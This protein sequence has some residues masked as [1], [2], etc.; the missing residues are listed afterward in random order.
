MD[1]MIFNILK[2]AAGSSLMYICYYF[3]LRKETIFRFNRFFL[4][5]ALTLP[6]LFLW[7]TIPGAPL[8]TEGTFNAVLKAVETNGATADES[9]VAFPLTLIA[10]TAYLAGCLICL[11]RFM[12]G[13]RKILALKKHSKTVIY[14]GSMLFISKEMKGVCSFFSRI[15]VNEESFQK[16]GFERVWLHEKVHVRQ[17]HSLDLLLAE[18]S[19]VILWFNPLTWKIRSALKETHEYLAD[20][21]VKEQTPDPA[22]YYL[23]LLRT[24]IGVQTGLAN[25]FNHSLIL[26]RIQMMKKPR[27]G[28]LTLLKALPVIPL[29][30]LLLLA[31]SCQSSPLPGAE[32]SAEEQMVPADSVDQ[33]P[34]FPGGQEA[35][36]KFIIENVRY[37]EDAKKNGVQGTVYVQF[38]VTKNG[39]L[40]DIRLQKSVNPGL[41]E[42]ALRVIKLMPDWVPGSFKGK[43]VD[44]QL[45]LPISFKLAEK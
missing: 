25:H 7:I 40:Q 37:P 43:A 20:D 4:L 6:W 3:F 26:K 10:F 8:V 12:T 33:M 38:T 32:N 44:T 18:I 45:T 39:K 9:G 42:E 21:G 17:L 16:S 5:A 36:S 22:G 19:C 15:Y 28:R 1:E 34:S 27:S 11:I 30:T 41:D 29:M 2:L 14:K 31:F 35:M 23:L 24:Q 13:L